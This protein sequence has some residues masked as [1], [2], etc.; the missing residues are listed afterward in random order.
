MPPYPYQGICNEY[1]H[2]FL[3]DSSAG[4]WDGWCVEM[5]FCGHSQTLALIDG[6]PGCRVKSDKTET[7]WDFAFYH[8][9]IPKGS[10]DARWIGGLA[11]AYGSPEWIG[12]EE[13]AELTAD[14]GRDRSHLKNEVWTTYDHGSFAG[15]FP[16][17]PYEE[18]VMLCSQHICEGDSLI[19]D[20]LQT[21]SNC[22]YY[23]WH[24]KEGIWMLL[25]ID[26]TDRRCV[27]A[28]RSVAASET[29]SLSIWARGY[30]DKD[31]LIGT[32]EKDGI[33]RDIWLHGHGAELI[34]I[35][36][37]PT[38]RDRSAWIIAADFRGS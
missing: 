26:E 21:D 35:S 6:E 15:Y 29:P 28:Y 17:G 24:T 36:L 1:S 23:I 22:R 13:E 16:R 34:E 18:A 12:T 7:F 25:R 5:P 31:T 27:E 14:R 8:A 32:K 2:V 11:N 37:V 19:T 33:E 38:G 9:G 20:T 30:S 10:R 4:K 3:W